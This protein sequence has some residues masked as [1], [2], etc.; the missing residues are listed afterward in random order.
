[1][2][3]HVSFKHEAPPCRTPR[4]YKRALTEDI[5]QTALNKRFFRISRQPD[6][7]FYAAEVLPRMPHLA[8]PCLR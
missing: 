6:P 8:R 5:F 4:E 1:M 2:L 3:V 7:P